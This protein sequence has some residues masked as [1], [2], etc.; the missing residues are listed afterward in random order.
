MYGPATAASFSFQ[1]LCALLYH[2]ASLKFVLLL[3]W[4]EHF[5]LSLPQCQGL[6]ASTVMVEGFKNV[7]WCLKDTHEGELGNLILNTLMTQ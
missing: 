4:F 3:T 6:K 5:Y 7:S 2:R 1:L